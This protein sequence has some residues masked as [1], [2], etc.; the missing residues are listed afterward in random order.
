[1]KRR[2]REDRLETALADL[3]ARDGAPAS[4]FVLTGGQRLFSAGDPAE[5]LYL[6][7]SGRLGVFRHEPGQ[8]AEFVGVVRGGEPVGEMALLAGTP[9]TSTVVALRDS[10]VLALPRDAFLAAA[11][12]HPDV[13]TELAR[14]MIRRAREIGPGAADPSVYGFVS[15]RPRSIRPFVDRVAAEIVRLGFTVQVIDQSALVS[16]AEWFSRVEESHDYVLYVADREDAAWA[17]L[18]AR[19]VDRLFLVGDA[20]ATPPA[21]LQPENGDEAHR[22]TDLILI[23]P[24]GVGPGNTPVWLQALAPAR[25]L[26]VREG[27]ATDAARIARTLTGASVGLALSGGGAR[28]YAH[29]G[30]LRALREAGTPFDFVGGASMG[31]VVAAG[32]ALG[33]TQEEM[34]ARIHQAFVVKSPLSDIAV[35]IIAMT[36]GRKVDALLQAHYGEVDIADLPL[37]FFCVSANITA[38]GYRV[39]RQGLL[40]RALRAS[41]SLPGVLPPVVDGGAVLVDGAV[42]KSFPADVVRA[43]HL[44]PV[45]G[46]D[47]SRARG[48]DPAVLEN[49][50]SWWRWFL[51]GE[52]RQGP[53]IVS[54]LM[55]SATITTAAELETSRA[56]TDLLIQPRL[57]GVEIRDFKA[58]DPAV[59][60]GY[61]AAVEALRDLDGPITHLRAR[62]AEAELRNDAGPAGTAAGT[63]A[64]SPPSAAAAAP[65]PPARGRRRGKPPARRPAAPTDT[66]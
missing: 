5:T 17:G 50:P 28:A 14:L 10:E 25:W 49:P 4:W 24:P 15:L 9:H 64:G 43:Q 41:I 19:Q 60:A 11:R 58:W 59:V 52:W 18:C 23:R 36:G 13:M 12:T 46:V 37:P 33:W 53:P 51:S 26:H 47:V 8:P 29:L 40:R 48:V 27:E 54:I 22:P 42:M 65:A 66:A 35:P 1:M 20:L 63:A 30:A 38:S 6:V 31:A 61:E 7:R 2:P 21:G 57:D 55:R 45:V 44:G 39:H 62:K 34:E 16:A 56:A 32:V 3:F